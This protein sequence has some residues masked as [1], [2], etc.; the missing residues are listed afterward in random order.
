MLL[1]LLACA[2]QDA[3]EAAATTIAPEVLSALRA[4]DSVQVLLQLQPDLADAIRPQVV[5]NMPTS[6]RFSRLPVM[7]IELSSLQDLAML[8][9]MGGVLRVDLDPV[10]ETHALPARDAESDALMGTPAA[11][12]RGYDGTGV[13][14]AVIDTGVDYTHAD[15]GA[16]SAPGEPGC[17]VV[18]SVDIA[19]DDGALDASGHGTNVAGIVHQVAPGAG[20]VALDV[21]SGSSASGSDVLAAL[22]WV[23]THQA[24]HDIVA[25]NMS[26]GGGEYA[27]TCDENVFAAAVEEAV[28]AGVQVVVSSGND[29]WTNATSYPGCVSAAITVGAV[30][31]SDLGT[32][33]WSTCTDTNADADTVTCFS[34]DADH[35][36]L[37]APGALISAAGS[38]MGGTSQASPHV[39]GAVAV[40]VAGWPDEDP[41]YLLGH[42]QTTGQSV[43]DTRSGRT[44]ARIDLDAATDLPE[45]EDTGSEDTGTR[46]TGSGDT[47]TGD[48]G[49]GDTGTED[50]GTEDTGSEDTGGEDTGGED[51]GGEEGP[52]V[53]EDWFTPGE[54][55]A[56]AS[57]NRTHLTWTGFAAVDGI[58]HYLLVRNGEGTTSEGCTS[59]QDTQV[60]SGSKTASRDETEGDGHVVSYRVCAVDSSGRVSDGVTATATHIGELPSEVP[61][62]TIVM[63]GNDAET[64][65]LRVR[66]LVSATDAAAEMCVS[67]TPYCTDWEATESQFAWNLAPTVLGE[68]TLWVSFRDEDGVQGPPVSDTIYVT[69]LTDAS[70]RPGQ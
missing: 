43:T 62:G 10:L 58:D 6:Q 61:M 36:D 57:E 40:M 59:S 14:V 31:D 12:L 19:P 26:L 5:A 68:R 20:I 9:H 63:N 55:T 45:P 4:E 16:C 52:W 2:P 21:F 47:G 64:D 28:A 53:N 27:N 70:E 38:T 8:Q 1:L 34:N 66:V 69:S 23:L 35:V 24:T 11:H 50:T 3:A 32:R 49:T 48:T 60:Y 67:E 56:V 51:T 13:T 54:L 65:S 44:H 42:L 39:A 18:A 37:L 15:F 30:Y 46:D 25:V 29:G 17:A 22:E 7:A 41:S 33:G